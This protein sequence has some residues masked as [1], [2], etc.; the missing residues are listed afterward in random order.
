M[1]SKKDSTR[2]NTEITARRVRLIGADGEQVG[3]VSINDALQQA[4]DANM[5]LV[6]ISPNA[7][8][9]VCKVMNFGKYQFEQNKKLQAA[10]K[11]QKQIQIKE[12]KFRPGTEEADYQVKLRNLIKFLEDGDKTKITVRFKGREL[13]HRELGIELLKR[14]ETD[15]D[16]VAVV[17]QFP[18]LEG[19][20]MVMVMGSRKRK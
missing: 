20:Q 5:D 7:D 4:Y 10:K 3:I 18:K 13:S 2:L 17:E 15:L 11:K 16:E 12:V 9:P 1:S 6:E 19:R 14:I 8:P